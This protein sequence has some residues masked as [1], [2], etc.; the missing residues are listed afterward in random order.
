MIAS[1]ENPKARNTIKGKSVGNTRNR[2]SQTHR[3]V[4]MIHLMT[5]NIDARGAKIRRATEKRIL[6]NYVQG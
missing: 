1:T 6:T 4:I 3:G 5:L 2:T